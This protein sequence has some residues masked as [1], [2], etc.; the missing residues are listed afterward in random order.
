MTESIFNVLSLDGGGA[1]G[2]YTIGVLKEVEALLGKPLYRCFDLIYGT[3]T[4]SIIA[5]LIGLGHSI[6]EIHEMYSKHIAKIVGATTPAKRSIALARLASEVFG[7]KHF[8]DMKTRIGVVAARWVEERP[9]IFK[10]DVNQAFGRQSTFKPGFGAKVGEA[11]QA[12]CS[13]YPIFDRM[14]VATSQGL[15]ELVDGGYCANNPTLY[16]ILDATKSLARNPEC[17]RVL[18]VGVGEY[19]LPHYPIWNRSWWVQRVPHVKLLQKTFEFSSRS[20]EQIRPLLFPDVRT[21]RIN[22]V[23]TGSEMAT[24]MLEVCERKLDLLWQRGRQSFA[25]HERELKNLLLDPNS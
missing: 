14:N 10:G 7:D 3:S 24:D 18:S 21:V 5:S 23:Y 17:I 25:N 6:D 20:M 13:A 19:P 16:A 4:G 2:F 22:D 11:V 12:S 1:K 9:M 8:G 15:V